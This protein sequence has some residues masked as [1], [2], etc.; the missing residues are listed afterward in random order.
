MIDN[1]EQDAPRNDV[2]AIIDLVKQNYRG[3]SAEEF[4][5]L[6]LDEV[7]TKNNSI[8]PCFIE[9][10]A[11]IAR[12]NGIYIGLRLDGEHKNDVELDSFFASI[13]HSNYKE[14]VRILYKMNPVVGVN[15]WKIVQHGDTSYQKMSKTILELKN[16][17][18]SCY[19]SLEISYLN[20]VNS[21]CYSFYKWTGLLSASSKNIIREYESS[22]KLMDL[23]DTLIDRCCFIDELVR[24]ESATLN[25][26]FESIHQIRFNYQTNEFDNISNETIERFI[27]AGTK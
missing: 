25:K 26:L 24:N 5:S 9:R 18:L 27:Y 15:G 20:I 10:F 16:K 3:D 6:F 19:E 8:P 7:I 23:H 1:L 13:E 14:I 17:H 4:A 21:P 11:M 22:R 12:L 2:D